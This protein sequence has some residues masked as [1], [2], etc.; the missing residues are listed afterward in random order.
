MYRLR[1]S[2]GFVDVP[3]DRYLLRPLRPFSAAERVGLRMSLPALHLASAIRSRRGGAADLEFRPIE[4]FGVWYDDLS[5]RLRDEP[6]YGAIKTAQY[7]NWRY[8]DNPV[9]RYVAIEGHVRGEPVGAFV[10][11]APA[12]SGPTFWLV[13]V[14]APLTDDRLAAA[15][16][17]RCL[18]WARSCGA[19]TIRTFATSRRA[20]RQLANVGFLAIGSSPHFTYFANAV[21]TDVLPPGVDW[22]FWHGDRD[23]EFY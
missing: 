5:E 2:V 18:T 17:W 14:L 19:D 15:L 16:L 7:L 8:I 21:P 13:D 12:D 11:R 9:R 3:N 22:N 20:R 1:R 23:N 10:V 6:Y 4:R